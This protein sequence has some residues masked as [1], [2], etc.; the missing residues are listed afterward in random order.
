MKK[1]VFALFFVKCNCLIFFICA[2]NSQEKNS[3]I[4]FKKHIL[5]NEFISEGVSVA[6]VNKDGK[7]DI[8]AG[9]FWF[10]APNWNKHQISKPVY[11]GVGMKETDRIKPNE[12]YS[13]SFLNFTLDVNMDGWV[14]M[15]RIG[16]PGEEALWYENNKNKAGNW[17]SHKV[18]NSVGNESPAFEDVD[19]DGRKD[20]IFADSKSKKV[21]WL[22]APISKKDS[23][24]KTYL[25]SNDSLQSTNRYTH[26]L[27]FAD[28][29]LDGRKDVIVREGWW[30]APIDPK[31]P[32]W[33]FHKTDIGQE[34]AQMYLMDLD[35]DGDQDV[36]S[37][38]AHKYGFWWHQNEGG[39]FIHHEFSQIFSQSHNLSLVDINGDGQKDLVSGKRF[40]AHN[41][42][43]PG[44][45]DPSLLVWFEYIPGKTPKWFP[46]IIDSDSGA[47]LQNVVVDMNKDQKMDIVVSNKKGVYYFEQIISVYKKN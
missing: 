41:A 16:L 44:D 35:G 15:I 14:D 26:G 38:S 40:L 7:T 47:G 33:N 9:S 30:E 29:N 32:D 10:E 3:I 39:K 17:N 23:T 25:I 1:L 22:S 45:L 46:H 4:H 5:S 42:G 27:G 21:V 19:N 8:L 31:T 6:D 28:M 36:I 2:Q 20:L 37:S 18:Y 11:Y 13:N 24:W 34:C 43:D 12:G